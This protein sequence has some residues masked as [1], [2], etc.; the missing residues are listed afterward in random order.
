MYLSEFWKLEAQDW[1]AGRFGISWGPSPWVADD[2]LLAVSSHG[3][4]FVCEHPLCLS[5]YK[6][7]SQIRAPLLWLHFI[8]VILLKAPSPNT[9]TL[10]VKASTYELAGGHNSV[11]VTSILWNMYYLLGLV[12]NSLHAILNFIPVPA[13][14]PWA[15]KL[16]S[17]CLTFLICKMEIIIVSVLWCYEYS[18]N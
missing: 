13:L 4:F 2:C 7:T 9:V 3:L 8:L 15:T 11:H 18:M 14:Q 10:R 5:S 16:T 6:D 17:L 1:G 12:L